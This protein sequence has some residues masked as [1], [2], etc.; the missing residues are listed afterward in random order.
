MIGIDLKS[1]IDFGHKT[2]T[3]SLEGP[4]NVHRTNNLLTTVRLSSQK[5]NST[6]AFDDIT[7]TIGLNLF[8]ASISTC[9]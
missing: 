9:V 7:A 4:V 8:P 2:F 3:V 5:N 6:D 1:P